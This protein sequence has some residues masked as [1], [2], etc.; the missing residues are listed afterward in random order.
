MFDFSIYSAKSQYYD[1]SKKL[2][3]GKIKDE[4]SGVVIN[5][6]GGLKPKM[7]LFLTD[8]SSEHKEAKRVNKNV[9]ARKAMKN[10]MMFC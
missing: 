3:V 9:V 1:D 8:D 6:F 5:K 2:V 10:T 4:R 7:N